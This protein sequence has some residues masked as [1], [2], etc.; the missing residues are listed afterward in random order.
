MVQEKYN[1][2][3]CS[4]L[5]LISMNADV[6]ASIINQ[7]TLFVIQLTHIIL[8]AQHF[9]KSFQ[10]QTNADSNERFNVYRLHLD[11][12]TLNNA[13]RHNIILG[14]FVSTHQDQQHPYAL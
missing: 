1:H 9:R 4:S 3:I 7:R 8:S 10:R 5:I 11:A 13:T 2:V 12:I 14:H 6:I